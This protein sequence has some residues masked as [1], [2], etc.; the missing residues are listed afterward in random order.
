MD[1]TSRILIVGV[2]EGRVM[3]QILEKRP[4]PSM[5]AGLVERGVD[6]GHGRQVHDGVIAR[7]LPDVRQGDHQPEDLR[8]A[9]EG[10]GV[11]DD[12]KGQQH[13]VDDTA[14]R[15]EGDEDQ[16]RRDNQET[17]CGR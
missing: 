1:S 10:D 12:A 13:L 4:A 15:G 5:S 16:V 11:I 8:H 17:K 7:A 2:M 3:F 14:V 6:G 9:H